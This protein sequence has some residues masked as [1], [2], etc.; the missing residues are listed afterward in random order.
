MTWP[1]RYGRI[2]FL[3]LN[4]LTG[5]VK[6]TIQTAPTRWGPWGKPSP[7]DDD[8][9]RAYAKPLAKDVLNFAHY[10]GWAEAIVKISPRKEKV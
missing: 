2:R 6:V 8:C 7:E 3:V 4:W 5:D 9:L 1:W 10:G